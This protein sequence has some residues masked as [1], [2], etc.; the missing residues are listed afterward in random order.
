MKTLLALAAYLTMIVPVLAA[1]GPLIH[2]GKPVKT[3]NG[4]VIP[5]PTMKKTSAVK[6]GDR[7]VQVPEMMVYVPAGK[8]KIGSG[9][10]DETVTLDGYCIGKFSVTNAEYRAFLTATGSRRYPRYWTGGTYP[11]G[12]ANHPVVYV[13]LTDA[14]AYAKWVSDKTGWNVIIPTSNQWE[15]AARGPKGF[16]YPW[17]DKPDVTYK[18]G[19]LKSKFS[20]NGVTAAEFLKTEPKKA[21]KYDN[22]KSSYF[23][24]ATTVDQIAAYNKY[25]Q[26]TY[27]SVGPNGSVR[28]W[29]NHDTYTG[30]IYTDLFSSLSK[31]GGNTVAV[32]TYEDGKS[33]YGCYDMAGNVWNWCDTLIVA[34]NGAEKGK[35]VNEIRGGSWYANGSSCK[36]VSIGEGRA[37]RG[38]YNTVGFR[39]A[40]IPASTK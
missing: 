8:A 34:T 24:K 2:V 18:D 1:D 39:I 28:G 12:K 3:G 38:A 7:T 30:F 4:V 22:K 13:S 32:G 11:E 27:L 25:G 15:K 20:F 33:G 16:I 31:N 40:M 19:V 5:D 10:C 35:K 36:C 9:K 21:V 37:A 14:Q 17:G 23:D 29:V 6:D 26:P